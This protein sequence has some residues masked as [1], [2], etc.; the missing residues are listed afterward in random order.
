MVET[1]PEARRFNWALP[2]CAALVVV[3]V[4]IS[5]EFWAWKAEF[6]ISVLFVAPVLIVLSIAL[7]RNFG[8]LPGN[9]CVAWARRQRIRAVICYGDSRRF[10]PPFMLALLMRSAGLPATTCASSGS[11]MD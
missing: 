9:V 5:M 2:S 3:A 6:F 8:G 4:Y 7:I 1:T 10:A 11:R